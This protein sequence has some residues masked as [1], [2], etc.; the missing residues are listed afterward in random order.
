[1]RYD[2]ADLS[3]DTDARQL[4]RGGSRLHLSPKAMDL[5][6]I[7]VREPQRVISKAELYD[8]LWPATFVVEGNLPVL[9][10]EIRRAIGDK[11]HHIIRTVHR[12][13]YSCGISVREVPAGDDGAS[14]QTPGAVHTL[15]YGDHEYRLDQGENLV[16]RER[17]AQLFL[18]SASVSRRHAIINVS[19]D[20]AT[21]TD[22]ASKNG[23]FIGKQQ[24][25]DE[26]PLSDGSIIRF[27]SVE[28]LYRC[29]LTAGPTET[30]R[31]G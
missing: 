13:G 9:I 26:A 7:L 6:S 8:R 25:R 17:T 24:L 5:L 27:G 16:G 14:E 28:V 2:F 20:L 23:T 19:G 30:F 21:V 3:L 22:L 4:L 18:P 31:D 1:M 10:R 11:G 29:G 15:R 12:T